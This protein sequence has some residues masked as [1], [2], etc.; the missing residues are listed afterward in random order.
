MDNN[1]RPRFIFDK[2]N[3]GTNNNKPAGIENIFTANNFNK[4]P[5]FEPRGTPMGQQRVRFF[6][7]I[8]PQ[9]LNPKNPFLEMDRNREFYRIIKDE[10]GITKDSN[11]NHDEMISWVFKIFEEYYKNRK[12]VLKDSNRTFNELINFLE[13][14]FSNELNSYLQRQKLLDNKS[15][16]GNDIGNSSSNKNSQISTSNEELITETPNRKTSFLQ[17]NSVQSNESVYTKK[18]DFFKK[19]NPM[20]R[21]IN[22]VSNQPKKVFNNRV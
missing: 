9:N 13:E 2:N 10:V 20:M 22:N 18:I 1:F 21:Q 14:H 4:Q 3:Y 17:Q 8:V 15:G 19:G 11:E 6:P 7:K 12:N 5:T 16:V